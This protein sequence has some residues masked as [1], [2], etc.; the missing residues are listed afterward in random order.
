MPYNTIA[1]IFRRYDQPPS[2]DMARNPYNPTFGVLPQDMPMPPD[3][4]GGIN[5]LNFDPTIASRYNSG[6]RQPQPQPQPQYNP[7][8][9]AIYQRAMSAPPSMSIGGEIA[10]NLL[11]AFVGSKMGESKQKYMENQAQVERNQKIADM[12]SIADYNAGL[13]EKA[14]E[15]KYGRDIGL[16]GMKVTENKP[17]N[18]PPVVDVFLSRKFSGYAKGDP[19][20]RNKAM[21]YF[22]SPEGQSAFAKEAP[23][24]QRSLATP[25]YQIVP[26]SEG[27]VQVNARNPSEK[28]LPTGLDKPLTGEMVT[29]EQQFG[30]LKDS[31]GLVR[32]LYNKDYVGP[33]GGRIGSLQEKTTGLPQDQAKFYSALEATKNALIYALS[34]KQINESEYQRLLKQLPD[35]NLPVSV[36]SARMDEF[37]RVL[38]S[39]TTERHKAMGGYGIPKPKPLTKQTT[40]ETKTIT[41]TGTYNGKKVIQ[42]SDGSIEY[43][44]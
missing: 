3:S 17:I 29:A 40:G 21:D 38:N 6:F 20:E 23:G 35:R 18:M 8:L 10:R 33:I 22:N 25:F 39:I 7:M 26:T 30:T 1:D 15:S 9:E 43:A 42:Y 32:E 28:I 44:K 12:K 41:K 27:F 5:A 13:A 2:E 11:G 31:M 19:T 24:L 36:F 16:L 34:G 4:L 14:A 37:D